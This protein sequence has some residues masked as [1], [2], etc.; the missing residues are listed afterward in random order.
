[1]GKAICKHCGSHN[2]YGISR[3][4][5]FYSKI[6]DWNKSKTA[7]FRDRQ[8]GTYTITGEMKEKEEVKEGVAVKC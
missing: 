2:V 5:G 7:E 3:V 8:K 6:D 4:V 1:M